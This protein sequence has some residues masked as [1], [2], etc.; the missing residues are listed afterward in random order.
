MNG[1]KRERERIRKQKTRG[2][3]ITFHQAKKLKE[4]IFFYIVVV[5]MIILTYCQ[6]QLNMN[7]VDNSVQLGD[8]ES[9]PLSACHLSIIPLS[10]NDYINIWKEKCLKFV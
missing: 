9:M 1:E 8:E 2:V 5:K 10:Q 7:G 6:S 3:H 4:S